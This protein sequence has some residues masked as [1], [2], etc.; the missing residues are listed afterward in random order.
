MNWR[1]DNMNK[2]IKKKLRKRFRLRTYSEYKKFKTNMNKL[3]TIRNELLSSSAR[4]IMFPTIK[5]EDTDSTVETETELRY[6]TWK[7]QKEW[8]KESGLTLRV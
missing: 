6:P 4:R 1:K 2:R 8:L 5:H 7:E 3:L